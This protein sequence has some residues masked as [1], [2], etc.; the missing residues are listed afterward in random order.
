VTAPF[1]ADVEWTDRALATWRALPF[2]T[3]KVVAEAVHAFAKTGVGNVIPNGPHE[4]ILFAGGLEIALLFSDD[5]LYVDALRR[6]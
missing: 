6:V 5:V 1:N 2:D 4:Y 3:A